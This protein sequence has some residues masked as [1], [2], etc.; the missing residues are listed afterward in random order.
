M[1]VLRQSPLVLVA[2]MLVSCSKE[3]PPLPT[4]GHELSSP[5]VAK[6]EPGQPGGRLTLGV[7]GAPATLNPLMADQ[8][9]SEAVTR[10]LFSSLVTIDQN[11]Q[12]VQPALAESWSVQPDGKTWTF[13]LRPGLHWS[14]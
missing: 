7:L 4:V 2:L 8:R 10:L 9:S 13:K 12:E 11:T 3:P 14:D 5:R 1:N 6:C